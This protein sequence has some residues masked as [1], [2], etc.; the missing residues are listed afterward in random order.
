MLTM[1]G[2]ARNLTNMCLDGR[3]EPFPSVEVVLL[4]VKPVYG[5]GKDNNLVKMH[6]ACDLRFHTNIKG[7]RTLADKL[8]LYAD[9]C[10]AVFGP[11]PEPE[12]LPEHVGNKPEGLVGDPVAHAEAIT[13]GRKRPKAATRR[14]VR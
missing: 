12:E 14:L 4:C 7:L 1:I 6:E 5:F 11:D 13:P 10:E 9:E 2:S 3:S 8:N